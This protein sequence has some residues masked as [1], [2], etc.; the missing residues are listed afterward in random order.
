MSHFGIISWTGSGNLSSWKRA[1]QEIYLP[2]K[3]INFPFHSPQG[4]W[5]CLCGQREKSITGMGRGQE[6]CS[7]SL[8]WLEW[9]QL[10]HVAQWCQFLPCHSAELICPVYK[11]CLEVFWQFCAVCSL[12]TVP[13]VWY[14]NCTDTLQKVKMKDIC[15]YCISWK[16]EHGSRSKLWAI[17]F[18]VFLLCVQN[19]LFFSLL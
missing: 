13:S 16:S 7:A 15:N 8:L 12:C 6:G 18:L 11:I 9:V 14:S 19:R 2:L 4:C 3:E 17:L 5:A 1:E 10:R